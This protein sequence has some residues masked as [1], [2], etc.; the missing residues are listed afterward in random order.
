MF[1]TVLV[2]NRGEIAVRV[3]ATLRRLGIHSVAIYSDEDE[4]ARHVREADHALRV[5]P[6]AARES[7][8]HIERV[9]EAAI[10]SGA[11][12]IHPGY[13]FLSENAA[14]VRACEEAGVVFIGP[15]AASVEMMGDKI[16]AKAAVAGAG[17]AVVPGRARAK[18]DDYELAAGARDVG[19]PVLVKPSAGGGGKGMRLVR[20]PEDL[21][22]AITSARRESAASFGDDTLFIERYV[23]RPRHLEVQILADHFGHAIHLGER[24]CSLQ[25]RHQ[26]VIEEAP[27]PLPTEESRRA[28]CGAALRVGEV[29]QYRG[30]GTVEFIVSSLRPDEFFFM[31]MNTRLQVEHPV[32]ELVTGIDLVEQQLRV[33]AG[34]RL[35]ILQD[36]VVLTGHAMEARIYAEDPSRD[37]LPTGGDLLFLGEPRGEGVRVDSSLV[38]GTHVGT[39]YDPMLAKVIAHGDDRDEAR[40]RLDRALGE[41]VTLG[42]V[43]N[44]TFLRRLLEHDDVRRGVLDTDL[45]GRML[46]DGG[47]A[48][49]LDE[50][51]LVERACGFAV[52][53][54]FR[55]QRSRTQDWP[56]G[57][58]RFNVL[59]GWR[60]GEHASTT[61]SVLTTDSASLRVAVSGTWREAR[62]TLEG[63]AQ[64]TSVRC[65]E[66]R[67]VSL[68]A[69]ELTID[70]QGQ[71]TRMIIGFERARTWIWQRGATTLWRTAPR[72][73]GDEASD[74]H[75]GEVRSPM[76]GV[77][78]H[79]SAIAGDVVA[80][81]DPLLVVEAMKMEYTLTAPF[82]GHVTDV[83][84]DV[85]DQVALDQVVVRVRNTS[86]DANAADAEVSR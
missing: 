16:R 68:H 82:A 14:F 78:I 9:L 12:A 28:L 5:G 64:A 69:V 30:V 79:V 45:I 25:R 63:Y 32:T 15:S 31:E 26:K 47:E 17:V 44:T 55:L 70:V 8:L 60:I 49:A 72:T 57:S 86:A 54:L 71:A 62:V 61:F 35:S 50:E 41:F 53:Q 48:E 36:D 51:Q 76:P 80:A 37:F 74:A 27:S 40:E 7:Y 23:E 67:D 39:T 20:S 38:P 77:V 65:L 22:A 24:E 21:A 81:G 29:A 75:N 52:A 11:Q 1:D 13:G 46:S 19:Y 59:D 3:I 85:G 6:T 33:A 4:G 83:G 34:E 66:C 42:V 84:V 56:T 2:A 58:S 18:M 43:T 10:S 73:R